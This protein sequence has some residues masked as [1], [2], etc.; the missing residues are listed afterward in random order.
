[1]SLRQRRFPDLQQ[2]WFVVIERA[3]YI[4]TYR[5]HL[6]T[7]SALAVEAFVDYIRSDFKTALSLCNPKAAG[8]SGRLPQPAYSRP[9]NRLFASPFFENQLAPVWSENSNC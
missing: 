8:F 2:R 9:R 6:R 3:G 5:I 4:R 1:M 7:S